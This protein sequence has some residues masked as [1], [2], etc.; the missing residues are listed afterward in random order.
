MNM[1][2]DI[3]RKILF[4][5]DEQ[6]ILDGIRRQLR[7]QFEIDTALTGRQGLELMVLSGPYAVV[8]SDLRMEEMDGLEFLRQVG[9][10]SP[11]TVCVM[12]TGYGDM[13]VAVK[14]VNE[15]GIFRFL[16]KPCENEVLVET[17]IEGL[18]QYRRLA[19]ITSY[20]YSADIIDGQIVWKHHSHGCV[21]VTG[22]SHEDIITDRS[23]W[24]TMVVSEHRPIA[25]TAIERIIAG[26]ESGPIELKIKKRDG[27]LRWI[28][29]TIIPRHDID[30][31]VIGFEG[32]VEDIT[33]RKE[34]EEA[35]KISESK[36]QKM[37]ANVPGLVFQLLMHD[38]GTVEFPFVSESS[39]ELFGID[40]Q[41][42]CKDSAMLLDLLS[43]SDRR[44]FHE[45]LVLS[46]RQMTPWEWWGSVNVSD[47]ERLF[48]GVG[49]P[50]KLENGDVLFDALLMDMTEYRKIEEQVRSLAKFPAEDPNPVLRVSSDG[51]VL[52]ANKTAKQLLLQWEI[53]VGDTAPKVI[54]DK[55]AEIKGT[56][57]HETIEIECGKKIYSVTL[58]STE[59]ADYVNL[60]ASDITAIKNVE[61]E[62]TATNQTLQE[63]DRMKNQFV[64]TVSHELRTPLCIFKNIVSNAMAGALGKVSKKLYQ[65]LKMADDSIDRLARIINDFLDIS[66]IEAGAMKLDLTEFSLN[67]LVDEIVTPMTALADNKGIELTINTCANDAIINA[68][69]D[70]IAQVLTNLVGNAIKFVLVNGHIE[71]SV[72]DE[73]DQ[74]KFSVDDDGPGLSKD[75]IEK[76]FDRFVQVNKPRE[77]QEHGTGLGLAITRELIDMHEGSLWVD[78][79]PGHGCCF[80]FVLPKVTAEKQKAE[81]EPVGA[82][83]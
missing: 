64:T 6:A 21:S 83:K 31:K 55:I 74:I 24:L 77:T 68:D 37:V 81:E 17:L 76:V 5:D 13:D 49:R 45:A 3:S 22:Y 73:D 33:E 71:V 19:S 27:S 10:I 23:L 58:A 28:R 15:G 42:L 72:T 44:A 50:E 11:D 7:G 14:A 78:S 32:L 36:Y 4:V 56:G 70:R 41:N 18:E 48:Q 67:E 60:Y 80:N 34:V 57:T 82:S 66:K 20:T 79:V 63:H 43:E 47:D 51:K 1:P 12:L 52:Y 26:D 65:S 75:E 8:V 61:R 35:L 39:R 16:S 38:D 62:L 54:T 53:K 2:D 40:P 59:D 29:D 30:G 69:R 25:K 46:A 9:S